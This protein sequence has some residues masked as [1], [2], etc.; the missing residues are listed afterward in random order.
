MKLY[1][2]RHGGERNRR[3]KNQPTASKAVGIFLPFRLY[4]AAR[5][6]GKLPRS[7]APYFSPYLSQG[8][9]WLDGEDGKILRQTAG[10]AI[11]TATLV[12]YAELMCYRPAGQAMLSGITE[13]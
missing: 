2:K 5:I 6:W 1:T 9:R 3:Q 11:F 7:A 13:A 10:K 8:E 12:K 4:L